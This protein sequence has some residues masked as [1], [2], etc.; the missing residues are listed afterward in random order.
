LERALV[1]AYPEAKVVLTMR[2]A[3]SWW[4]SFENTILKHILSK[5]DM[6]CF[7]HHLI[8]EQ[9]FEGHPIIGIMG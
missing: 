3:E 7:A 4:T 8:S 1:E 5:E 9:V 2:S 6:H